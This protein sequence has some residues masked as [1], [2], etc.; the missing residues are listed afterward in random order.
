MEDWLKEALSE[1][2]KDQLALILY[3][4]VLGN[5]GEKSGESY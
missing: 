2:S 5:T 1:M 4:I 3:L